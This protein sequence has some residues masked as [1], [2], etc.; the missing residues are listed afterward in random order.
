VE[1]GQRVKESQD[2]EME[3]RRWQRG[4]IKIKYEY[5]IRKPIHYFESQSRKLLK[6]I[7]LVMGGNYRRV[8]V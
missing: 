1:R 3:G 2:K 4:S 6:Q 5:A 7:K 8:S